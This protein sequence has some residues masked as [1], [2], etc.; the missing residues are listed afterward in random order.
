MSRYETCAACGESVKVGKNGQWNKTHKSCAQAGQGCLTDEYKAC[1]DH[2]VLVWCLGPYTTYRGCPVP[3]CKAGKP[4]KYGE[5]RPWRYTERKSKGAGE[6]ESPAPDPGPAWKAYPDAWDGVDRGVIRPAPEPTPTPTPAPLPEVIVSKPKAPAPVAPSMDLKNL[7]SLGDTIAAFVEV[8]ATELA[9]EIAHKAVSDVGARGPVTI[10][11][12][13]N[14]APLAT[15]EGT[16]HKALPRLLKLYAAGFRNF[17]IVGPA[18][19]GKTTLAHNMADALKLAF[20]HVSCT[21]GMS[22]TALTGR[23]IPNLTT[24][25]R[26]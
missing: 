21:G 23:A 11:W 3:F 4:N 12:T 19:S 13:V 16:H 20:A 17:L 2:S 18:G 5:A 9:T 1:P 8:R 7:G 24:P 14:N 26:G 25:G 22:E 15:I 6:D 10:T